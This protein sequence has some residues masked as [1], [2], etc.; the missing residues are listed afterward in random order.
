M[1]CSLQLINLQVIHYYA[2]H[3]QQLPRKWMNHLKIDDGAGS[4][5]CGFEVRHVG[6]QINAAALFQYGRL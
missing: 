5:G 3:V 1:L 4:G 6:R 2:N